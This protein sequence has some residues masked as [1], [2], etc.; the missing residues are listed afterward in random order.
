M[1]RSKKLPKSTRR[2]LRRL[3]LQLAVQLP[4]DPD[5]AQVVIAALSEIVAVVYEDRV[6]TSKSVVQL[7][8]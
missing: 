2:E 3:A 1:L 7:V 6:P 8:R 5:E 4:A